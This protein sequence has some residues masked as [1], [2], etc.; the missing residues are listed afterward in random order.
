M[1]NSKGCEGISTRTRTLNL[2]GSE[3]RIQ[4][5][6]SWGTGNVAYWVDFAKVKFT[7]PEVFVRMPPIK[8]PYAP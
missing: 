2:I 6:G 7:D 5:G 1:T 3:L 8:N 4:I